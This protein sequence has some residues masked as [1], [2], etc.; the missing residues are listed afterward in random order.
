MSS[1]NPDSFELDKYTPN[2]LY[3]LIGIGEILRNIGRPSQFVPNDLYTILQ[4]SAGNLVFGYIKDDNSLD[5]LTTK[6]LK[7]VPE[8]L[9]D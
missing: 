3:A 9:S 5:S 4:G 2:I 6:I 8:N 1:S 7:S